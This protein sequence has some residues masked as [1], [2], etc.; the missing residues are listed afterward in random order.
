MTSTPIVRVLLVLVALLTGLAV[1][2]VAGMLT[3]ANGGTIA[4]AFG[5]GGAAFLATVTLAV[6]VQNQ[7]FK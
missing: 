2:E 7:L 5:G 1:G 3:V 6:L 4:L